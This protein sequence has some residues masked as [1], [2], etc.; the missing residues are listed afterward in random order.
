M[1]LNLARFVLA[2]FAV[3]LW[4]GNA[5]PLQAQPFWYKGQTHLHT[6]KS[7]GDELP[8]RVVRWYRDH[9]YHF[10][11]ITDH[12]LLTDPAPLDTDPNDRFILIPGEE[13]TDR[14]ESKP[15]HLNGINIRQ[16]IP[17]RH[18]ATIIETLQN[19][20][21]AIREA[22]G[23]AQINHPAWRR[24]FGADE[25]AAIRGAA[26]MELYNMT[27][28]S[29]NYSAGGVPGMEE[30]WDRILSK[31]TLIYGVITDDAHNFRGDFMPDDAN[32]GRGWVMV[33][34][35]ELTPDAITHALESGDFYATTGLLLEDVQ[36]SDNQY[37]LKIRAEKDFSYTT[38]F[39]GWGGQILKEDH[40]LTPVYSFTGTERYV[41][42]R[43][44]CSTGK[45]AF[46]QPVLVAAPRKTGY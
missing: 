41:R 35:A 39:I 16:V 44:F 5:S 26:L 1:I 15:V 21:D 10:I 43:V 19:N 46:T 13:V 30:I 31:G 33:R 7:D 32:P 38:T 37:S 4:T 22:G 11:V 17:P 42:A 36:I 20:I 12:N 9:E 8:H 18:G 23:I 6:N 34:A 14:A 2:V 29:N 3:A 45:V 27:T 40:S 24:S 25:M 28:D